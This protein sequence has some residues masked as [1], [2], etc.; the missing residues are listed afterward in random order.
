V[1]ILGKGH[2]SGQEFA[3]ETIP[4]DDRQVAQEEFLAL[5]GATTPG[6]RR[7]LQAGDDPQAADDPKA[8]EG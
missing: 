4:F 2:E 1:L 5:T 6:G 3:L 8:S 7:G